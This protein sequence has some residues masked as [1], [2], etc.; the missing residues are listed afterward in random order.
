MLKLNKKLLLYNIF[1]CVLVSIPLVGGKFGFIGTVLA[2]QAK[3]ENQ[4]I[5][6][7]GVIALDMVKNDEAA[8]FAAGLTEALPARMS[9]DGWQDFISEGYAFQL[10]FPDGIKLNASPDQSALNAGLGVPEGTPVWQFTLSD[11]AF[12][13]GTNLVEASLVIQVN[14]G[15]GALSAC[16]GYQPGSVYQLMGES[17][18]LREINGVAFLKDVGQEGVMGGT[19]QRISYRSIWQEACYELTQVVHSKNIESYPE[20]TIRAFDEQSVNNQLD[21]VL[22]TFQFLDIEAT[23]PEM[24]YPAMSSSIQSF[25]P[26]DGGYADGI[27]V[28]HW[29]GDINWT[30]VRDAG[31]SFAFVKGTEGVGWTDPLFHQNMD[32][33]SAAGVVQGVY[34]FARPDLGNTGR[35]E[36]EW[37][38][39]V[40]GDYLES[41]YL[42]PVLDL[43]VRG[44]M[45]QTALST[46]VLEWMQTV[47]SR[48]GVAPMLYTNLYYINNYLTNE[49]TAYDLWIA[50]WTTG[51]DPT[52]T[53]TIPPTGKW[54]DWAFWQF[55]V[56]PAGTV[57]G[58]TTPID[59]DIF[60]GVE[61]GLLE[62][63]AASPLWVSLRS[64]AYR[65]PNPYFADITANVNGDTTG[66]INYHFWWDCDSLEADIASVE[67]SCGALP[68]PS[69]GECLAD[70]IGKRCEAVASEV[71]LAEHT[72]QEIGV[73]MAKVIVE[74][75]AA[76]PAEDRYQ[77]TVINPLLSLIAD[78]ASPG[79]GAPYTDYLVTVDVTTKPTLDGV[80]EVEL[81]RNGAP[82]LLDSA[83]QAVDGDMQSINTYDLTIPYST[84]EI[85]EYTIW[86][87]Y[88][89]GGPCPVADTDPD[90]LAFLYQIDWTRTTFMDVPYDHPLHGYI[91]ALWDA[92][93]TA[94]CSADPLLFCPDA[95][96]DRAQSAVFM[97]R[98]QF[99]SGYVPPP[100]PWDTFADDW[101]LTDISWAEKWA[102]G[103]WVEGLTAGCQVDPLLYCPRRE[104]PRVEASV[105]GLRMKYGM[106]YV[107]PDASGTLFVDMTD[108]DYWGTKWAEQA[109]LDN[110]LPECGNQ[111]GQPLFC[112]DDLLDRGWGA[113][114]V[115]TA[116][117]LALP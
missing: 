25:S 88:R 93:F 109:Y 70:G 104:L 76:Q 24:V 59:L 9:I 14:R 22:S 94:G 40:A 3:T 41:G 49:V 77:I 28:S 81:Y 80:V 56:A 54:S 89:P 18:P 90:D 58:I 43:E 117:D 51:C 108:V 96:L 60:N 105:F 4:N 2:A 65:A 44:S 38:L 50:Y 68:Q 73:Y 8:H 17:L 53:A 86:A 72:Y 45:G 99:G 61:V 67:S 7:I 79:A 23:F 32:A 106:E 48:T 55:C 11:P 20:N 100:E 103:M 64:D 21:Q 34:H 102:E 92:G 113:Y 78:P 112:P 107:P 66:L 35:E 15:E 47:E 69:P 98:G 16:T 46:W 84:N 12:F 82:D 37:F 83:C 75:G 97:L 62:Y 95:I 26:A 87:R 71:Q 31:Y 114:L 116:K 13:R 91:Q 63:D 10:S 111:D 27:D 6:S 33:G 57:P 85:A 52:V 36:A 42:R 30:L 110:L 29:Q 74:R 19:Y 39:S 5:G 115:V 1:A 101:S